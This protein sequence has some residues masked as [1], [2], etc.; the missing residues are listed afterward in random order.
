MEQLFNIFLKAP[1]D[2]NRTDEQEEV[3]S[4]QQSDLAL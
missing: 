4:F 3:L 2:K 1:R